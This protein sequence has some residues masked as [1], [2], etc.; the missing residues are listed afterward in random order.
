MERRCMLKRIL[1][2]DDNDRHLEVLYETLDYFNFFVKTLPDGKNL[3]DII[4][5]FKPD[6]LLLDY[7]LPGSD[8]GIELCR[9]L[10]S[11]SKTENIPVIIMSG[12]RLVFDQYSCCNGFLYKP[13]DLE[14]LIE[15]VDDLLGTHSML[16]HSKF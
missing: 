8:N 4:E 2:V 16:L 11:N 6:L 14:L 13:F 3:F 7:I 9:E 12:Y 1:I 5:E 15:K 10:K